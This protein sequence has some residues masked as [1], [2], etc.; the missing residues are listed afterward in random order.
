MPH[1]FGDGGNFEDTGIAGLIRRKIPRIV[2][3]VNGNTPLGY[4]DAVQQVSCDSQRMNPL[5]YNKNN[6]LK[7]T[8]FNNFEKMPIKVLF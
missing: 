3:F 7:Y 8:T 2:S 4:D 5:F 6:T 1:F